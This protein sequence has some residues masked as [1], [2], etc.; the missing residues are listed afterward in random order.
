MPALIVLPSERDRLLGLHAMDERVFNYL[1]ERTDYR[2]GLIGIKSSVSYGRMA[3]DLSEHI[4]RKALA[5]QI[6]LTRKD[7]INS[8]ARLVKANLF[9]RLEAKANSKRLKL[10]RNFWRDL[11]NTNNSVQNPDGTQLVQLMV[12]LNSDKFNKNSNLSDYSKSRW[13][14]VAI[15][16]GTNLST[17]TSTN[18]FSMSDEWSPSR[19]FAAR[20]KSAGFDI[21]QDDKL[22]FDY[23]LVEMRMYWM[24]E[25]GNKARNQIG[26]ELV[27]LKSMQ[28]LK[29]EATAEAFANA[30]PRSEAQGAGSEAKAA[31]AGNYAAGVKS[32]PA[33]LI[34]PKVPNYRNQNDLVRWQA[35]TKAPEP[36]AGEETY[37]YYRRMLDWRQTKLSEA[38]YGSVH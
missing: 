7:A 15:P 8:T 36:R 10:M 11:L 5:K 30:K 2:S 14:N 9:T 3:L 19:A 24:A 25:Q 22:L 26:W 6:K 20:V 35:T 31:S 33:G 32:K 13:H 4:P 23:A 27:L 16:D 12:L 28:H 37:D 17:T 38:K 34:I 29:Q 1:C 21:Q 18:S